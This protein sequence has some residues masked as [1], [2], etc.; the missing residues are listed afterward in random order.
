MTGI[1]AEPWHFRYVGLPHSV[2]MTEQKIVL[3]EYAD[4]QRRQGL[5]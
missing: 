3:E 2:I 4:V 5:G 1:G